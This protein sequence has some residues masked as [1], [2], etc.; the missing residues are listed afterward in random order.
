MIE[1][2]FERIGK[3][4]KGVFVGS[5]LKWHKIYKEVSLV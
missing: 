5:G 4:G 3:E 1:N 2:E